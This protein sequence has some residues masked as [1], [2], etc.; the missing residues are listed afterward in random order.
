[1]PLDAPAE[2]AG[3]GRGHAL[4]REPAN[5]AGHRLGLGRRLVELKL[6]RLG[7]KRL[8]RRLADVGDRGRT[9][10]KTFPPG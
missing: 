4:G 10:P 8:E 7:E 2:L 3:R 1:M 9:R 6:G 5:D